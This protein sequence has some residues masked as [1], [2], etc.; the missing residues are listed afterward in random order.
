MDDLI[1][2][3]RNKRGDWAPSAYLQIAPVFVLP[4]RPLAF[5]KW[6]PGYFLPWN[7]LFAASAVAYALFVL[8]GRRGH[9]DV[10]RGAGFSGSSLSTA[11][12]CSCSTAP[13]STG[14]T[15]RARREP[16]SNTTRKFP[17][18][19]KNKAFLF[20]QPER[21]GH[22]PRI[23]N[24]RADLDG[25]RGRRSFSPSPTAMRLGSPSPSIPSTSVASRS[26]VPIFHEFHFFCIHRLIHWPPA[27]PLGAQHPSPLGQS[28]AVVVPVDAPGRAPPLFLIVA[29]S[30]DHPLEPGACDLSAQLCGVRR[31]CRPYWLRQDRNERKV[32]VR[33]PRLRPLPSPQIFRSELRR[34]ARAI[35]Q[36]VRHLARR[37]A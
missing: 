7:L 13:S 20:R 10:V 30:R 32:R 26:I 29:H 24:R 8:P 22:H 27:L 15:C 31:G 17:N 23:R 19:T 6:L 35:G 9:E 25:I 21:R 12:R 16:A 28:V 14:S 18:D 3:A 36:A 2:G 4:P 1:Y 33:Q 5:L 11:S 34:R 37:L